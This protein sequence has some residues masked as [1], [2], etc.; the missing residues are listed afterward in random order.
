MI[1]L[2]NIIIIIILFIDQNKLSSS[3]NLCFLFWKLWLEVILLQF[4]PLDGSTSPGFPNKESGCCFARTHRQ[5]GTHQSRELRTSPPQRSAEHSSST[6]ICLSLKPLHLPEGLWSPETERIYYRQNN[7]P[8]QIFTGV[9][10]IIIIKKKQNSF[11]GI[12]EEKKM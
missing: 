7:F 11:E 3:R 1:K 6:F 12:K 2:F 9:T 8:P 5:T 10:I 4:Y